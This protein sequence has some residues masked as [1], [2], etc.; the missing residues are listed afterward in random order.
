MLRL[1]SRTAPCVTAPDA[2]KTSRSPSSKGAEAATTAE[3][4]SRFESQVDVSNSA[5]GCFI[6]TSNQ[7]LN[8]E[9]QSGPFRGV[10][11]QERGFVAKERVRGIFLEGH[12][13]SEQAQCPTGSHINRYELNSLPLSVKEN[14]SAT[15]R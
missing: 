12:H 15:G 10:S 3:A 9:T 4:S 8:L 13:F 7:S 11:D 6:I 5:V 14:N 2:I 1:C